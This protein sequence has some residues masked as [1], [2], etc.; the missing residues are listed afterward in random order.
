[1][2]AKVAQLLEKGVRIFCPESVEIG[3]EVDVNRISGDQV[4]IHT[5]CKL[6]G[7]DT[8]ILSRVTLGDEAPVTV[9]NCQLGQ[10]VRLAGGFFRD[11]VFLQGASMGLGAHVREAT[12]LEEGASGAHTVGLKQTILFPFVTLGSL[13]NFCDVLM[14]GGTSRRD[15]SEVG[16][17]YIHFNYTPNQDKATA[18][19]LGD[20]SRGVML[21]QRPIFLGGQ[22]GLVG[23]TRL[24][25]GTM[26]AAGTICRK[27]VLEPG[28]LVFEA[29]A[30]AGQMPFCAGLYRNVKRVVV[31]NLIYLGNLAAL[32]HWYAHVRA[33]FV[34]L[35]FPQALLEALREKLN[36]AITE[37]IKRLGDFCAK[38]PAS[39]E[40]Y[41]M[42]AG[43]NASGRLLAQKQEL[44][45][46]WPNLQSLMQDQ[47][48]WAGDTSL[49]DRFLD[50]IE[51]GIR[52]HGA[53]YLKVIQSLPGSISDIGSR[54][55]EGL[56]EDFVQKTL[57]VLPAFG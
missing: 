15:H 56:V 6:L 17:S 2:D 37:R 40:A 24:A 32:S 55:L 21:N 20:V 46:C 43:K 8:L 3:S 45:R 16:S 51:A 52:E 19:L 49:R 26:T 13:I 30:R 41:R 48:S 10:Q 36:M 34:A 14:S 18:S 44:Y 25:F 9:T 1:M 31:N 22:G 28:L 33:R 57:A 12:I 53:E 42:A 47:M 4:S 7:A 50:V 11:S 54:W 5:G 39:A 23:P 27:D 35:A 38:M 29:S